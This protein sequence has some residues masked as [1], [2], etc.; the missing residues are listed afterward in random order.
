MIALGRFALA[1][2]VFTVSALVSLGAVLG[3]AYLLGALSLVP[4]AAAAQLLSLV[5]P[6][7]RVVL[8]EGI[9]AAVLAVLVPVSSPSVALPYLVV[10][11]LIAALGHGRPLLVRTSLAELAALAGCATVS[12]QHID[13]PLVGS[14]FTWLVT[15]LGIGLLGAAFR[16]AAPDPAAS[17]RIAAQLLRQL[18]DLTARLTHGLDDVNVAD[19]VI[20]EV[21][22]RL[23]A[24]VIAV[25]AC[26]DRTGTAIAL[27]STAGPPER[28]FT[29]AIPLA[30][31][32]VEAGVV[33]EGHRV[34][35]PML[36]GSRV[37]GVV[38]AETLEELRPDRL[39][40]IRA[41]LEPAAIR[42]QAARLF[43][44]VRDAATSQERLRIA[45]EVHDGV[46]Q[47]VASLG[48]L[49]DNLASNVHGDRQAA[50]ICGLR[51][52]VTRVVEELRRSVFELRHESPVRN[53][54]GD[55]LGAFARQVASV[56]PVTVHVTLDERLPRLAPEVEEQLLHIA[57]EAMTNVRKHSGAVNLWLSCSVRAPG[58][59]IEVRDDGPWKGTP[60]RASTHS[61]GLEIM[62]ERAQAIG[63]TLVIEE[64]GPTRSGTR[65]RVSLAETPVLVPAGGQR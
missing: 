47:D 38:V 49:V 33:I 15:A 42:L 29:W 20:A 62:R 4:L 28:V 50:M 53:G 17:Y 43:G 65:V 55:S 9:A 7:S 36:V 46:A 54:L 16:R 22:E 45:R 40:E 30:E 39:T 23:P 64:P 19:H 5:L 57:Q 56:C 61:Q 10:P 3:P 63:A 41:L 59:T 60:H 13:R 35:V 58:A 24:R 37:V 1:T 27:R 52:E 11:V 21:G 12:V 48:Y 2:R 44:Q 8:L 26:D 31:Q 25:L 6:S 32:A 18:D 51:E 34:A 14:A